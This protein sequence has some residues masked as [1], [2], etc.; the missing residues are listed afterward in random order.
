[1]AN[2]KAADVVDDIICRSETYNICTSKS[3][4]FLDLVQIY[5]IVFQ[6]LFWVFSVA[7]SCLIGLRVTDQKVALSLISCFAP[8]F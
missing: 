3:C 6:T 1:M 4:R 2:Y 5:F 8:S 7:V